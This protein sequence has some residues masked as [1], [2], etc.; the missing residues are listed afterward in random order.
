M[1][2]HWIKVESR[3][4]FV[5]WACEPFVRGAEYRA[6]ILQPEPRVGL[7]WVIYAAHATGAEEVRRSGGA[8]YDDAQ[9][10][11]EGAIAWA[12]WGALKTLRE[13]YGCASA[14]AALHALR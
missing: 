1:P 10:H 5:A 12:T 4:G 3:I 8:F 14:A 6:A 7:V 13:H 2:D 9:D 11:P